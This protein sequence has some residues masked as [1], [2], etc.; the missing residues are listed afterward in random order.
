MD[1]STWMIDSISV[2]SPDGTRDEYGQPNYAAARTVACRLERVNKR[3]VEADGNE[4]Y[5][6]HRIACDQELT[7]E[8]AYWLPGEDTE[9]VPSKRPMAVTQASTKDGAY[10]IWEVLL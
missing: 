2:A 1:I 8:D 7:W 4:R 5:A 9:S 6:R 3:F 10:T